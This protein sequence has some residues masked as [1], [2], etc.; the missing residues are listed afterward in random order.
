MDS[1]AQPPTEQPAPRSLLILDREP[2]S[3]Y[4]AGCTHAQTLVGYSRREEIDVI[5]RLPC[6]QW[7]CPDCA[8]DRIRVLAAQCRDAAPNRL[9]TL[10]VNPAVWSSPREA[11]DG[12]RRK[13]SPLLTGLRK[14]HGPIEY[15]RVTELTRAGWPHYHFLVK[16]AYIPQPEVKTRWASL[17]GAT[18]VDIRQVKNE[19]NTFKYLAKYLSKLHYIPWTQRHLAYSRKFFVKDPDYNPPSLDL[20]GVALINQHPVAFCLE[21]HP[22]CTLTRL[23]SHTWTID[24]GP[25]NGIQYF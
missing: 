6:K 13:I 4:M 7:S 12:T 21:T 1:T 20:T 11:F 24:K 14:R 9:L 22:G 15:L 2:L 25:T 3:R 18:I 10:T 19:F 8:R 17:T 16:S 5:I 23:N